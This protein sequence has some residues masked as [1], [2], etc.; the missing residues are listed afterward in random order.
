M[1]VGVNTMEHVK[2]QRMQDCTLKCKESICL[3]VAAFAAV[4]GK[5]FRMS[6]L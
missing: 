1:T 6:G 4:R 2:A 5:H 3:Y